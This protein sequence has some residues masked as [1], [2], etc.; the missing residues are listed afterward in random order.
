MANLNQ[1]PLLSLVV[2]LAAYVGGIRLAVLGRINA[3]PPPQ[4]VAALKRFLKR[5]I[6]TDFLLI[7]AGI[8]LFLKIFWSDLV[9]GIAAP[10]WFDTLIVWAFFFATVTL[11]LHH[12][13]AWYKAFR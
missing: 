3:A 4:D 8:F 2:A 1:L 6:P 7:V 10:M 9:G 12:V 11:V 13:V 5:L